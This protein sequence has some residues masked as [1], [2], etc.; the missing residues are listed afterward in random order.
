MREAAECVVEA[1]GFL[2]AVPALMVYVLL[3]QPCS[4][5]PLQLVKARAEQRAHT[6]RREVVTTKQVRKFD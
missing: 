2:L 4:G 1:I 5:V 6:E 3:L